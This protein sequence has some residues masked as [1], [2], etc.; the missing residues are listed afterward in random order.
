MNTLFWRWHKEDLKYIRKILNKQNNYKNKL[1]R[2]HTKK[3]SNNDG[4]Y[5]DLKR[6]SS[7]GIF[8]LS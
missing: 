5:F 2:Q 7:F 4:D 3:N 8:S 1:L 6:F